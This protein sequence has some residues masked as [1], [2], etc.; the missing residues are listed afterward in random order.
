MPI[1]ART[2]APRAVLW[3]MDGTLADSSEY[4]WL[5]WQDV[6]ATE[7]VSITR[8]DFDATFG[9]RNAEILRLWLGK[10]ADPE[11]IT[12]IG[13]GKEVA[14]RALL[15]SG[16]VE[17]LPG[18]A[19]WVNTLR[20]GGWRQAIAS[21]APRANIEAMLEALR[22][23]DLVDVY[24]GAE[25]V[26][27]GKPEPDVFLTAAERLGVPPER[28]VVVEDA[29]AGIG[30]ARRAGMI[31]VGVGGGAVEAADVV[32]LSLSDLSDDVFADML[33]GR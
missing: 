10:D 18:A 24:L 12:R 8:A 22:F 23:T 32:V 31:S 33:R 2:E 13:D 14:Y 9:W 16:G 11:R 19:E 1:T 6:L 15:R 28:C 29:A 27:R 25:D 20:A 7:G 3:D 26:T 30:S 4:H 5:S 17:P 21:S